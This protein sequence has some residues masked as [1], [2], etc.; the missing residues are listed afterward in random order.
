MLTRQSK[1]QW[2]ESS[3][4]WPESVNAGAATRR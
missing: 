1:A 4:G 2:T 3:T